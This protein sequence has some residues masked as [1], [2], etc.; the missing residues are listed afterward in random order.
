MRR[1]ERRP[2]GAAGSV[3]VSIGA[4][5]IVL[6]SGIVGWALLAH[7]P[8]ATGTLGG[9]IRFA[10]SSTVGTEPPALTEPPRIAAPVHPSVSPQRPYVS[11]TLVLF[12]DTLLPGD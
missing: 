1:P 2:A 6:L 12:N 11:G 7:P 4:V 3:A 8:T 9:A 10:S 5:G